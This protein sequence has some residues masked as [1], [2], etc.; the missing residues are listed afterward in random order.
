MTFTAYGPRILGNAGTISYRDEAGNVI[1]ALNIIPGELNVFSEDVIGKVVQNLVSILNDQEPP[2][3][4]ELRGVRSGWERTV[5]GLD[6]AISNSQNLKDKTRLHMILHPACPVEI[7]EKLYDRLAEQGGMAET[8]RQ[9]VMIQP[10]APSA[11]R[12]FRPA[13]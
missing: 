3:K 5:S 8:L 1:P 11:G 6:V 10:P 7:C 2:H 12:N 13:F 4:M 9:V